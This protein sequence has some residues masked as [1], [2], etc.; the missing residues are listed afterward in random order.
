MAQK[1]KK[2]TL[3]QTLGFTPLEQRIARVQMAGLQTLLARDKEALARYD[4][5]G[6]DLLP[7]PLPRH[8]EPDLADVSEWYRYYVQRRF[9]IEDRVRAL[10]LKKRGGGTGGTPPVNPAEEQLDKKPPQKAG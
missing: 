3:T 5:V 8:V 7:P 2:P 10:Q 4:G 6:E 1:F 9:E